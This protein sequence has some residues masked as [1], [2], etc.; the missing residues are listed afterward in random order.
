MAN[1]REREERRVVGGRKGRRLVKWKNREKLMM[2]IS[3]VLMMIMLI[4][5]TDRNKNN[6][7]NGHS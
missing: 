4:M 5:T 2:A 6:G 1:K 3:I 7:K